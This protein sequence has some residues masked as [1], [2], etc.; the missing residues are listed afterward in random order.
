MRDSMNRRTGGKMLSPYSLVGVLEG[1]DFVMNSKNH[2]DWSEQG[3][4]DLDYQAPK[5]DWF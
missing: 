2:Q 5:G 1:Q 3:G 4:R